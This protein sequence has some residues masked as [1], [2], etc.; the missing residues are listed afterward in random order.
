MFVSLS[1]RPGFTG[2]DQ[3]YEAPHKPDLVVQA[4]TQSIDEC[5]QEVVKM[6]QR[7]VRA[8]DTAARGHWACTAETVNYLTLHMWCSNNL[9]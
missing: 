7:Q 8:P 4:G 3:E 2:I 5:V 9:M 1:P 6:L